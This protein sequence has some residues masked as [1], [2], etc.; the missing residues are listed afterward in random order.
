MGDPGHCSPCPAGWPPPLQHTC[1]YTP[2][3]APQL[4][5]PSAGSALEQTPQTHF[6]I[7]AIG[8]NR[9]LIRTAN[10]TL[11]PQSTEAYYCFYDFCALSGV[12]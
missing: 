2:Q 7:P 11:S 12:S 4:H 10:S 6:A 9:Q 5:P 8:E 1:S 3:V